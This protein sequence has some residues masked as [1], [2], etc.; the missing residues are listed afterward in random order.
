MPY[1]HRTNN[2]SA[3]IKKELVERLAQG[4][5]I[6]EA[7]KLLRISRSTF[8]NWRK[9]DE[10]FNAECTRLLADPIHQSRILRQESKAV[11]GI[12]EDWKLRFIGMYRMSGDRT[13]ALATVGNG[14]R[15]Q[16]IEN[17][18]NPKHD[19]YDE[20]FHKLF[21]NEEQKRLWKIEDNLL[22]KAEHDSPSARFVLANL[23]KDKY[24][25]LEGSATIQQVWFTSQGESD[26]MSG[27]QGLGFGKAELGR[28]SDSS[29][30]EIPEQA[31]DT[32]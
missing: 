8:Y 13:E 18:L 24:G 2:D 11:L 17:A 6:K 15:A 20:Q 16:D 7:T 5:G 27:L 4:Y 22:K 21:L 30:R 10:A 14:K 12:E 3:L 23:V 25:K 29:P 26:A 31:N 19:T 28:S 1:N 9:A 32:G